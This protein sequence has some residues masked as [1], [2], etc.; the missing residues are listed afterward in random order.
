MQLVYSIFLAN[1]TSKISKINLSKSSVSVSA[2]TFSQW[3][4]CRM[5][6]SSYQS[7][8]ENINY[9]KNKFKLWHMKS[10][11]LWE[12]L[13]KSYISNEIRKWN[14]NVGLSFKCS[15]LSRRNTN[16]NES[17]T[18]PKWYSLWETWG[19]ISSIAYIGLGRILFHFMQRFAFGVET[20]RLAEIC[21]YLYV[22][23]EIVNVLSRCISSLNTQ[24]IR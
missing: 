19:S 3:T 23:F 21:D 15:Y 2:G 7:L 18:A 6:T 11:L 24:K 22:W 16:S 20:G 12:S 1:N 5:S 13:V 4:I 8:F 9:N 14:L 10:Y 17:F